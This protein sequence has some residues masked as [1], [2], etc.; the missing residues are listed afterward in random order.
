MSNKRKSFS[1]AFKLRAVQLA[2]AKGNRRVARDLHVDERCIRDW[3]KLKKVIEEAVSTSPANK[4]R[5]KFGGGGKSPLIDE[6]DELALWVMTRRDEGIKVSRQMISD[7]AIFLFGEDLPDFKASPGWVSKFL[8]RWGFCLRRSTTTGQLLPVDADSKLLSFWKYIAS[9]K[10]T[11]NINDAN[12]GNMD[13]TA[14]W[15]DMPGN[16]TVEMVGRKSVPIK[17]TGKDY[18]RF[19]VVLCAMADGRKLKPFVIFKGKNI[20][21]DNLGSGSIAECL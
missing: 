18:H 6:E 10:T 8:T 11:W 13:E 17:T 12:I 9:T 2:E 4:T 5:K 1:F 3:R 14:V 20:V 16:Y 21:N 7:K 19:T 15:V